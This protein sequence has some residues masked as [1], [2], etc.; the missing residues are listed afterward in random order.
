MN[1]HSKLSSTLPAMTSLDQR[2]NEFPGPDP[3]GDRNEVATEPVSTEPESTGSVACTLAPGSGTTGFIPG[4]E[5][6]KIMIVDDASMTVRLLQTFL[7]DAG[8]TK[9]VTTE[10]STEAMHLLL[11]ER[12]D[13]VLLDLNMPEVSGFDI[14]AEAR[15]H[16]EMGHMPILIL[17]ASDDPDD[18]LR[19]LELGATDFLAKPVDTSELALRLRNTLAAKAYQDRL[20]Y[21]DALTDLPN[22]QM[23]LDR[24]AD[25]LSRAQQTRKSGAV[26]HINLDRFKHVNDSLG[27]GV[28]DRILR[29]I[30]RRI[31]GCVREADEICRTPSPGANV[32][33]SRIGGDEFVVLL[34]RVRD[35]GS[36]NKVADR[37]LATVSE[38]IPWDDGELVITASIG[39][40]VFPQQATSVETLL[41]NAVLATGRAKQLGRGRHE[42][43]S[44]HCEAGSAARLSL[45]S[46]LHRALGRDELRLLFQPKV[47]VA[48]GRVKG[49]EALLRWQHTER[50]QIGPGEFIPLA[51]ETGLIVPF[52]NWVL[53]TACEQLAQ[54][55]DSGLD[56]LGIAV[57]VASLQLKEGNLLG[58]VRKALDATG[59]DP[60]RL[61]LE[62]TESAVIEHAKENIETLTSLHSLGVRLSLDDFGTGYSSLSYLERLPIDE[63]KID[64]SFVSRIDAEGDDAPIVSAVIAMAQRLGL[65]VVAEGVETEAQRNYLKRHRCDLYQG[66]LFAK[67]L[68]P[69]ECAERAR[70]A[71]EASELQSEAMPIAAPVPASGETGASPQRHAN[72]LLIDDD[73]VVCNLIATLLAEDG[74]SVTAAYTGGVGLKLARE[75]SFDLILLDVGLPDADGFSLCTELCTDAS[76]GGVPVVFLTSRETRE[77][78]VRGLNAGAVDFIRKP[79]HAD[80]LRM[81][82]RNQLELKMQRDQL[83]RIMGQREASPS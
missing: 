83:A 31:A 13:V 64:R 16:P 26:L 30:A 76:A 18:K 74:V 70:A 82:V 35:R 51:E 46:D 29:M 50:G 37:I 73:S 6:A 49:A 17:T 55:R 71:D 24:L 4:V 25:C 77:D 65:R 75:Q 63:L 38:P 44:R 47:D 56:D 12:P 60:A 15:A 3:A 7:E 40:L 81:R 5:D 34:P 2:E 11:A 69:E 43:Y 1:K 32:S 62:L 57:N 72:V 67:P 80:I 27:H 14:L 42:L 78:E 48:T 52:G 36:L 28:G 41:R 53:R 22:R 20:M 66:Y 68:P 19:A 39:V 54:W 10:R 9:F 59:V 79:V 8:Y 45:E 33:G 21:Y 23:F 58:E 61:T